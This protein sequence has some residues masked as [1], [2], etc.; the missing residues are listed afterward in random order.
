ASPIRNVV[1][2]LF[3]A[4]ISS[5]L[6]DCSYPPAAFSQRS[7][8]RFSDA[9]PFGIQRLVSSDGEKQQQFPALEH[10]LQSS[11]F[12]TYR[13]VPKYP[14]LCGRVR[15]EFSPHRTCTEFVEQ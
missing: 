6:A 15:I 11:S 2:H 5:F 7:E 3:S 1:C 4:H 9:F 8:P 10:T 14:G 13:C 12:Q